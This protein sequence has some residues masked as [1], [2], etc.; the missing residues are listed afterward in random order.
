MERRVSANEGIDA[1]LATLLVNHANM[2]FRQL[3]QKNPQQAKELEEP[4]QQMSQYLGQIVAMEQ[5]ARQEQ[6]QAM[7]EMQEEALPTMI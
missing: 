4:M 2:H 6:Q 1:E 5:Q 7:Q 3:Q